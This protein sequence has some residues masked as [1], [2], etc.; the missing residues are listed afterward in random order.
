MYIDNYI[1]WVKDNFKEN[2]I[3]DN[4]TELVTPFLNRNNDHIYL[5]VE[6]KDNDNFLLTDGGETI[7]DLKMSGLDLSTPKRKSFLEL[8]VNRLGVKYS[9]KDDSLFVNSNLKDFAVSKHR[10]IQAALSVDDIFYTATANVKSLFFEEVS[11]FFD[12]HEIGYSE[13]VIFRGKS[14]Y[15]YSYDFLL[16]KNKQNPERLIRLMN[17]PTKGRFEQIM[18][19]WDDTKALRSANSQLI[20][21]INDVGTISKNA[22]SN[23]MQG[24]E[25][26][27]IVPIL[28]SEREEFVERLG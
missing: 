10:L 8:T 1:S 26:Y 20:P 2:I 15:E 9:S 27:D 11:L 12:S 19:A 4:V 17:S 6:K 5:Y 7:N 18:F 21:I 28:W 22:I 3:S 23:I 16:Q 13:S 14:G 25:V 24:F